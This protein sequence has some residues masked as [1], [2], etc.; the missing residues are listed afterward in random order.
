[1]TEEKLCRIL[2]SKVYTQQ[3]DSSS[4]SDLRSRETKSLITQKTT[5][6]IHPTTASLHRSLLLLAAYKTSLISGVMCRDLIIMIL[7]LDKE[8]EA[9]Q[10][11]PT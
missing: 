2:R 3:F 10:E 8:T 7:F 5:T 11:Q 4:S 9:E 6:T 1:M